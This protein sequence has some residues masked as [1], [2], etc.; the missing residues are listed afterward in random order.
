[1][2]KLLVLFS[3]FLLSG[4]AAMQE[5]A[6][7]L[8]GSST[9]ALEEDRPNAVRKTFSCVPSECFELVLKFANA[10][11][12]EMVEPSKTAIETEFDPSYGA[13]VKPVLQ[14]GKNFD[15]FLKD[16]KKNVIVVMGVPDHV[17]TTEVG[18]FFTPVEGGT[19]VEVTS[20]ST[21]A[22]VKTSE[23]IFNELVRNFKDISS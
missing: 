4:C 20:L 18:V 17:N 7:I 19:M 11:T 8:W 12:G 15:V 2:K 9:Q 6:K 1:M 16:R 21:G 10:E 14:K 3:L 23:M 5:D 22:K 13:N